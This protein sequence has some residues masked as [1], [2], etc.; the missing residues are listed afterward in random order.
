MTAK[1]RQQTGSAGA[2]Q[3]M[4]TAPKSKSRLNCGRRDSPLGLAL[5]SYLQV[6]ATTVTSR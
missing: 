6:N 5:D 2:W 1:D 4:L 3:T